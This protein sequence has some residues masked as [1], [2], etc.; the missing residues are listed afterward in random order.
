M[1]MTGDPKREFLRHTLATVAYRGGK[2]LRDPPESFATLKISDRSRTPI[3]ILSHIV[4]L[5]DWALSLA[6]G[7]EAWF[8]STPQTWEADV[9]RFFESLKRFEDFLSS[10]EPLACDPEKLFQGPIADSL[11]HIGQI[12]MLRRVGGAQVKGENYFRA[13]ISSGSV[14]RKQKPPVREF[15]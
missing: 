10:E 6:Q 15:D 2:A 4:D 14:G 7:K 11:T 8:N 13:E 9:E 1:F 3:E 5:Y 12:G